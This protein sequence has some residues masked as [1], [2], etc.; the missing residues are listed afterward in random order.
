MLECICASMCFCVQSCGACAVDIR[1]W[2]HCQA[3]IVAKSCSTPALLRSVFRTVL[4]FLVC[5]VCMRAYYKYTRFERLRYATARKKRK[6]TTAN[7]ETKVGERRL[8]E[9]RWDLMF[10][11][12]VTTL[13]VRRFFRSMNR[14]PIEWTVLCVFHICCYSEVSVSASLFTLPKLCFN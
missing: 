7:T 13:D 4:P 9:Q 1:L 14:S 12:L 2:L 8:N 3:Y 11:T 5:S 6:K 10:S